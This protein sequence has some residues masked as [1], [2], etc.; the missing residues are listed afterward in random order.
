[1]THPHILSLTVQ[2]NYINFPVAVAPNQ[3][4]L[5]H[6][7]IISTCCQHYIQFD[8]KNTLT[9]VRYNNRHYNGKHVYLYMIYSVNAV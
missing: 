5:V 2:H 3:V 1:M 6:I 7:S 9:I 4:V 8:K